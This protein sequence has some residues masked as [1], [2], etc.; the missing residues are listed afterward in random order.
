[1]Y[2]KRRLF[3]RGLGGA[4]VAAP[5]LSSVAERAAKAAGVTAT[6][7]RR[8]VIY[9]T[10]YGCITDRWFPERAHG[11][12]T[13]DDFMSTN[14]VSLAPFANK[15]LLPRG[16][17]AMNQ[18]D[19]SGRLGQ[20]NDPHTQV[21]GSLLTCVPVT[22]DGSCSG[23]PNNCIIP[24]SNQA[25]NNARPIGRSIDHIAAEQINQGGDS[26][27]LVLK[28]GGI[29]DNDMSEVSYEGPEQPF[30][31]YGEP[32]AV[33]NNLTNLF[34]G[35]SPTPDDYRVA[36]GKSVID[37]VR[38]DLL[39]LKRFD[40]SQADRQKLEAWEE[41]LH[42]SGTAVVGQHCTQMTADML[43]LPG[44]GG[45]GGGLGGRDIT[46]P[47][48][49]DLMMN[50]AVLSFLCD[51]NRVVLIKY[52]PNYTFSGLGHS[53]E[54]HGLS[55]RIGSAFMGGDCSTGVIGQL[56]E[57][58][59]FHAEKFAYLVGKMD[60]YTEGDG[61]L[62]D[63]TAAVWIQELS[64]GNAHNLNNLPILQVGSCG[65]YFKV[66]QAV[67]LENGSE[68]FSRG[69]SFGDCDDGRT[70][71]INAGSHPAGTPNDVANQP[72]NKYFCNLLNALGVKAN[73]D[74]FPEM[75]GTEEVRKFGK[76]DDTSKF[77]GGLDSPPE[78]V[79]EGE[80]TELRA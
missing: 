15:I 64:D 75:G 46:Q 1:M 62:L 68:T 76:F 36:R 17:R 67:N 78:F 29:R 43:G 18:W 22:P 13:A 38:D 26:K 39:A 42:A 74:G 40:M 4:A 50:L 79:N 14:L 25:K 77:R 34:G 37:I 7:P 27:P 57:I 12:L 44:G 24:D 2:M 32:G 6:A 23:N 47:E 28:I 48:V 58:D 30:A 8:L 54:H 21:T 59:R 20:Q 19:S 66:G 56:E 72:I 51:A 70:D 69:N 65:G 35:T 33:F 45:G 16:I 11:P 61:T 63:S 73:A 60:D 10:H 9:F 71:P 3:L 53:T 52:P 41:L 49:T 80:F 55:H 5:F 31:G